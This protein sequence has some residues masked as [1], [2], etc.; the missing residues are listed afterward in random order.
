MQLQNTD[1]NDS[2]LV[3][4]AG[5]PPC[6]NIPRETAAGVYHDITTCPSP[7]QATDGFLAQ[8]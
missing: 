7:R 2:R 4:H 1:L 5:D 3:C 8:K 6:R